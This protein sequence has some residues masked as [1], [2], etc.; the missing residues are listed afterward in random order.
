MDLARQHLEWDRT[1]AT[2]PPPSPID[3]AD[4]T[5][6]AK[7]PEL[8]PD[9]KANPWALKA[10]TWEDM[11]YDFRY[12]WPPESSTAHQKS[13]FPGDHSGIDC[14]VI[15]L[16]QFY[17]MLGEERASPLFQKNVLLHA[18]SQFLC[19]RPMT[20]TP[21]LALFE[22]RQKLL[23][24][25]SEAMVREQRGL[26]FGSL[27]ESSL[28][29]PIWEHQYF[30]AFNAERH[31]SVDNMSDA[32]KEQQQMQLI[33][34][35]AV[36]SRIVWITSDE[37][38]YKSIQEV[39]D[40]CH[41]PI[42]FT[43]QSSRQDVWADSQIPMV[44]RVLFDPRGKRLD[45][46]SIHKLWKLDLSQTRY[47]GGAAE[48][49]TPLPL[50]MSLV[51]VVR[52]RNT[53]SE[54]DYIRVYHPNGRQILP[55]LPLHRHSTWNPH[56]TI[57]DQDHRYMLVYALLLPMDRSVPLATDCDEGYVPQ[58]AAPFVRS[59]DDTDAAMDRIIIAAE[60]RQEARY[61][62]W[63][64]AQAAAAS[65]PAGPSSVLVTASPPG[66]SA[67]RTSTSQHENAFASSDS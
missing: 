57:S 29:W 45:D 63:R 27:V 44:L 42:K 12:F 17:I 24:D 39:V 66:P 58:N 31:L 37:P 54:P 64:E 5:S 8:H 67:R 60:A 16:R 41:R 35:C 47:N 21:I 10:L 62:R 2:P 4:A 50:Q 43:N 52:G 1:R 3:P 65:A 48:S 23:A 46:F 6:P 59:E 61:D 18:A 36:K 14:A 25:V 55:R 19:P 11:L 49:R 20:R 28:F 56:W 7:T 9:Y 33:A 30:A 51:A 13:D 34:A 15:L 40:A 26:H 38:N 22:A 32:D 53:A